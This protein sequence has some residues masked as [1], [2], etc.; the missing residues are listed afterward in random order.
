MEVVLPIVGLLFA[1]AVFS[2]L[3]Y[4]VWA[5]TRSLPI[6]Q[7]KELIYSERCGGLAGGG[8]RFKGPFVR[9]SI[10]KEFLVLSHLQSIVV[11]FSEIE[12]VESGGLWGTAVCI[13]HNKKY[14]GPIQLSVVNHERLK[15]LLEGLIEEARQG[16]EDVP[17]K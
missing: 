13:N 2:L 1:A 5:S 8:I 17:G 10:Y 7:N 4:V 12:S 16:E 15:T 6:E 14:L 9:L 3:I 11:K